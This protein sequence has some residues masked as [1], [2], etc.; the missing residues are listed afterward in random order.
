MWGI[1]SLDNLDKKA[2]YKYLGRPQKIPLSGIWGQGELVKTAE[3]P[4]SFLTET[5]YLSDFGMAFKAGTKVDSEHTV[6]S[7]HLFRAPE[8]FHNVDPSFASDMWSYMCIFSQLYCTWIPWQRSR[9]FAMLDKM[10]KVLGPLPEQ[11][12]GNYF[13]DNCDNSWYD[14]SKTSDFR[15]AIEGLIQR[16]RPETSPT[17]RDHVLSVMSKV[18]CY[19]PEGRL[20]ATQLLQDASFKALMEIYCP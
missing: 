14:Q 18:F 11:W 5:I 3:I 2:K 8:L 10:V 9:R 16:Q 13:G 1:T 6:L 7:P 4:K 17:E 15:S 20:T 19:R 12:K